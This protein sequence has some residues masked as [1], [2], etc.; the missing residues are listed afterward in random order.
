MMNGIWIKFQESRMFLFCWKSYKCDVNV[1][2]IPKI[3]KAYIVLYELPFMTYYMSNP[4]SF[5][6]ETKLGKSNYPIFLDTNLKN[7]V[8]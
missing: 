5:Y 4:A 2:L 1:K 8:L 7:W 6:C 3:K